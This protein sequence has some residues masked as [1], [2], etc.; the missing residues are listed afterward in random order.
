MKSGMMFTS[1]IHIENCIKIQ[2]DKILFIN[3]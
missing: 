2:A 3:Y 1:L